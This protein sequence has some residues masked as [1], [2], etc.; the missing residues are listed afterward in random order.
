[1]PVIKRP[2]PYRVHQTITPSD[3]TL[4]DVSAIVC[5][6]AGTLVA[7]D[8]GGV[9]VSYPLTAGQTLHFGPTKVMAATTGTYAGLR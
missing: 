2:G 5:L 7:Q 9:S 4:L 1:M 3:A 8:V 6:T